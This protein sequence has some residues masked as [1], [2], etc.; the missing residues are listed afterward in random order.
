M[1]TVKVSTGR[2]AF[3]KVERVRHDGQGD[4]RVACPAG[5]DARVKRRYGHVERLEH[6]GQE[7]VWNEES[8]KLSEFDFFEN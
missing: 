5:G 6:P 2:R 1:K 7:V 8:L 4:Q 3:L